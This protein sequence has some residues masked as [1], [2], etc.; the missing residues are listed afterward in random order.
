MVEG[1]K[2]GG[3]G[4]SELENDP[5]FKRIFDGEWNA[6]IGRQGHEKKYIQ[7]EGAQGVSDAPGG[8]MAADRGE[9]GRRLSQ[10]H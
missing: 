9:Y 1:N 10:G 2:P 6:C 5:S 8:L 4:A 7:P 3:K